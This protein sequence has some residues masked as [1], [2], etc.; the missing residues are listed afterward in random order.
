M[1]VIKM[2][3]IFSVHCFHDALYRGT[4]HYVIDH[5]RFILH[6]LNSTIELFNWVYDENIKQIHSGN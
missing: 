6:F 3:R 5:L 2:N 1:S 4:K